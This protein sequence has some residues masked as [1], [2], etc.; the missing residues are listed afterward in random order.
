MPSTFATI[1]VASQ[2][3]LRF[4]APK[5]RAP[6]GPEQKQERKDA[7]EKKQARIDAHVNKWFSDTMALAEEMAEEFN[8]KA[9]YFHELFFQGGTHMVKHQ[10]VVN[11]YNAFKSEKAAECRERGETRD[12]TELHE[13]Y[14]DEY[15]ALTDAERTEYVAR[16]ET[17]RAQDIKLQRPTP[18]AKI[19]DVAN[20]VRNMKLLMT[21]L[22]TCV[23]IEG[24]FCIVRDSAD[25]HMQPQWFFTSRELEQYMPIATRKKW[26]TQEVGTKIEVFAVAGCDITSA[27][28]N[29]MYFMHAHTAP[30]LLRTSKQKADWLKAGIREGITE[31]LSAF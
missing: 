5:L 23:G 9:K 17:N 14:I 4:T 28:F 10:E 6:L 16:F 1:A 31:K 12:A 30:D 25:F 19:Q 11:P 24:F 15:R 20:I 8:M 29:S 26:V 2:L 13:E 7:R 18:R 3:H 21:G 27:C 22:S